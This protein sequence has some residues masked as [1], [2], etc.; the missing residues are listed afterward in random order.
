[1]R[2][3]NVN[4][5][6]GPWLCCAVRIACGDVAIGSSS[7]G[8]IELWWVPEPSSLRD[9]RTGAGAMQGRMWEPSASPLI[10]QMQKLCV[11]LL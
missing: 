8:V 6:I 4:S 7:G 3:E 11:D 9:V 1:M 5:P 2:W 10:S